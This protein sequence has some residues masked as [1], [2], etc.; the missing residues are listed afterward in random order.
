[1]II[2]AVRRAIRYLKVK[3]AV[4]H[5]NRMSST[6]NRE[7]FVLQIDKNINVY[8]QHRINMLITQ[9]ILK[10]SLSNIE[11]LRHTCI[12]TTFNKN[13]KEPLCISPKQIS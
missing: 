9:G 3:D 6:L 11:V 2:T 10:A 13:K 8:D 1:M 12:Y 4:N 7:H 5:A